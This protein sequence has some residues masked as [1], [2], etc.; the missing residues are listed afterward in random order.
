VDILNVDN[1]CVAYGP[2]EVI[3]EVSFSVRERA[4]TTI[5]G[6][7]GAGKTT[8]LKA[9]SGLI[10]ASGDIRF[11]GRRI[12]SLPAHRIVAMGVAHIPDQRGTFPALTVEEN[13]KVG[14]ITRRDRKEVVADI[15]RMYG[16]FPWLAERRRQQAGAL[17]GGEQQMLAL[18][19]SLMLRPRLLIL[20]EPSFGVAP[21]IIGRIFE[22]L[23]A[24]KC[25]NSMSMLLIEQN[26]ALALDF[27]DDA[28]LLETGRVVLSGSAAEFRENESVKRAYLGY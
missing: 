18:A 1:L 20:D 15:E 10:R 6:A 26:A 25:E 7:N 3:H 2:S 4:V 19:R 23:K 12:A 16:F 21:L 8:I 22:I 17:S 9:I 28:Y 14:A 11:E 27:A 5:L 13:L 24:L